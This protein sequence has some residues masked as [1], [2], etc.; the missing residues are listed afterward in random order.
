MEFIIGLIIGAAVVAVLAYYF[1]TIF[2]KDKSEQQSVILLEKI[3]NVSKLITIESDFTEIMHH[4]DSMNLLLNLLKS[5]KK[6][7]ISSQSKV[8]VGFDLK[9]IKI[10]PD[11]KNKTLELTHFPPPQV[12]SIETQVEYY[13][14]SNG[15]FNKFDAADLTQI[16]VKLREN[17]EAKIPQS[18]ILNTAQEKALDTIRMIEQIVETFGWRLLYH[19]LELPQNIEIKRLTH[20]KK[21]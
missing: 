13:D 17:I 12:L 11:P 19:E 8:M 10:K 2:I 3:R 18:G 14:I 15:L 7:I 20:G 1:R 9:L 6:A 5:D 4:K 16:N 21:D